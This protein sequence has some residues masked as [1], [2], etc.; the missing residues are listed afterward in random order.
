MDM[1]EFNYPQGGDCTG[2][3]FDTL[4]SLLLTLGITDYGYVTRK[5][6]IIVRGEPSLSCS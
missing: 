1:Q 6:L 4:P 2:V 5:M 3:E